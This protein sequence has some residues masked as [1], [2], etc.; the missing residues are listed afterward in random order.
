MPASADSI[1]IISI[2]QWIHGSHTPN[3]YLIKFNLIDSH[4]NLNV[5]NE[6]SSEVAFDCEINI[7]K[8]ESGSLAVW[9]LGERVYEG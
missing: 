3:A 1:W 8:E 4:N 9:M 7:R 2:L 6:D 5:L